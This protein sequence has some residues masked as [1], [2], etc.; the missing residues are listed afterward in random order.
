MNH[1]FFTAGFKQAAMSDF[2]RDEYAPAPNDWVLIKD[3][4]HAYALRTQSIDDGEA[5][6]LLDIPFTEVEPVGDGRFVCGFIPYQAAQEVADFNLKHALFWKAKD[7]LLLSE[8]KPA[9]HAKFNCDIQFRGSKESYL[10]KILQI[11]EDIRKGR[12]YQLNLLRW[13]DILY[14]AAE[15][16]EESTE[17]FQQAMLSHWLNGK[18]GKGCVF[19]NQNATNKK[20]SSPMSFVVS[21]SPESFVRLDGRRIFSSPIKGT[22]ASRQELAADLEKNSAELAMITDLMRNDLLSVCEP[23][24]VNVLQKQEVLELDTLLHLQSTVAGTLQKG[25]CL[26]QILAGILPVGSI[27]GAPKKEVCKAIS[28]LEEQKRSVSMGIFFVWDLLEKGLSSRVLIRTL[29]LDWKTKKGLYG[30]GSG[31][32]IASNP[33][34]EFLEVKLKSNILNM[35]QPSWP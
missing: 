14:Q 3:G 31:I 18:D 19:Y 5:Q 32:T 28:E 33:G 17:G 10:A 27:T 24:S 35:L 11:Q 34:F 20:N 8:L 21:F 29:Q 25:I 9:K 7:P 22:A 30:V 15:A 6:R 4:E 16:K 26:R 1:S 2:V 23:Q 12:Y 13:A